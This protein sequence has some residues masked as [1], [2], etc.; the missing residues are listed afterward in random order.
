MLR[1]R[2]GIAA[3]SG[4]TSACATNILIISIH[5]QKYV[6]RKENTAHTAIDGKLVLW[7]RAAHASEL[8]RHLFMQLPPHNE[9]ATEAT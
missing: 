4:G 1:A 8:F 7:S 2:A 9:A 3:T 6:L 5:M